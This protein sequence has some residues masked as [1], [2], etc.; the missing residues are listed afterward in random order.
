M[1]EP[2]Q[3]R[4][5]LP[6][7]PHPPVPLE[8]AHGAPVRLVVRGGECFTSVK[9]VERLTLS[10]VPAANTAEEIARALVAPGA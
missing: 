9:W 2:H 1:A 5:A 10:A 6:L 3:V 7:H 4:D 8:P